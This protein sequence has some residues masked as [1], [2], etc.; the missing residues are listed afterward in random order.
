[1]YAW[2][3]G[4]DANNSNACCCVEIHIC[5][6]TQGSQIHGKW[7]A[8]GFAIIGS[9]RLR[10]VFHFK[11]GDVWVMF[12]FSAG[13]R[14]RAFDTFACSYDL[15]NWT[16]WTGTHLVETSKSHDKTYA[17]KPWVLKYNGV[18][19]YFYCAVGN[20]GRVIAPATSRD[21]KIAGAR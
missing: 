4:N 11:H 14:P 15:V 13:W 3:F 8:D 7:V 5:R 9:A 6:H 16:K 10:Q 1:L 19:Y 18:V 17:H 21:L 12:Y 20:K 2:R